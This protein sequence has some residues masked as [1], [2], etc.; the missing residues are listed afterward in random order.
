MVCCS[1][2]LL[3]W[4]QQGYRNSKTGKKG[5]PQVFPVVSSN[6]PSGL[7]DVHG[8]R[9]ALKTTIHSFITTLESQ[10]YEMLG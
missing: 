4:D 10:T 9:S 1:C 3:L 2:V 5:A 6:L 8:Q 7:P